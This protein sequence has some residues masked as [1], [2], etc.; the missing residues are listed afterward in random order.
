[1]DSRMEINANDKKAGFRILHLYHDLMNL[2]GDWANAAVLAREL[3]CRGYAASVEKKS[4]GDDVDFS[5]YD[6]VYIGSGTERS[7]RACYSHMG[8]YKDEIIARIRDGLFFLATG[9]SHELF[10]VSILD[11]DDQLHLTLGL[12]DLA[13]L[14]TDARVT[15]DCLARARFMDA[16]VVGF[17]NRPGGT[18]VGNIERPFLNDLGPGET[19]LSNAE[20]IMYKNLLGTY[21]TGPLLVRNPPLLQYLA[22][23]LTGEPEAL[24]GAASRGSRIPGSRRADPFFEF[25]EAAYNMALAELSARADE[26]SSLR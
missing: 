20:G 5:A 16:K 15:S 11:A 12:L 21:L 4:V 25:Q 9:I 13:T 6:F 10:G 17:I 1:M 24:P 23:A 3:A 14:R 26:K 19:E 22:D 7:Q 8:R 18:Q 2:Y